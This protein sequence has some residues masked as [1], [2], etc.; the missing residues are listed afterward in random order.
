MRTHSR[1]SH[2]WSSDARGRRVKV[3]GG[4][5]RLSRSGNMRWSCAMASAVRARGTLCAD[6]AVEFMS[7]ALRGPRIRQWRLRVSGSNDAAKWISRAQDGS[8]ARA[9]N[10][11]HL[12]PAGWRISFAIFSLVAGRTGPP[13]TTGAVGGY[14]ESDLAMAHRAGGAGGDDLFGVARCSR[15]LL[16]RP[17][18]RSSVHGTCCMPTP[19]WINWCWASPSS[20]AGVF[21]SRFRTVP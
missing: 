6:P 5:G 4:P 1:L 19:G 15:R 9:R 8:S 11:H 16:V 17:G 10:T 2:R 21:H 13:N 3:D 12:T 18:M 20:V 14:A 7:S